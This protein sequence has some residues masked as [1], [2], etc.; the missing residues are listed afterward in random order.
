MEKE[1]ILREYE[2]KIIEL[3]RSIQIKEG[4]MQK[5]EQKL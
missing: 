4:E 3:R 5:L 2:A 1:S